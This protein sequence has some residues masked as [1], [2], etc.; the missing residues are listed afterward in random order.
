[1]TRP[2]GAT[3]AFAQSGDQPPRLPARNKR[4]LH[5]GRHTAPRRGNE[6]VRLE[7]AGDNR[8]DVVHCP[9]ALQEGKQLGQFGVVRVVK[10]RF[11]RNAVFW[12]RLTANAKAEANK[13]WG[14]GWG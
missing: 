14:G 1:M 2:A 10:P 7:V 9:Q 8:A 12:R 3:S 6:F 5:R 13:G 11:N 4:P